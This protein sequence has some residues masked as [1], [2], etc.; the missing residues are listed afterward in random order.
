MMSHF[1]TFCTDYKPQCHCQTKQ[2]WKN[3]AMWQFFCLLWILQFLFTDYLFTV[4]ASP[5]QEQKGSLQTPLWCLFVTWPLP[6]QLLAV[7]LLVPI[8]C[9]RFLIARV[10]MLE[11]KP[12]FL[13]PR[14]PIVLIKIRYRWSRSSFLVAILNSGEQR[15]EICF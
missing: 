12:K 7:P 10:M 1:E 5:S 13:R 4:Q 3:D 14:N 15:K 6:F 8:F 11:A 2:R 9:L